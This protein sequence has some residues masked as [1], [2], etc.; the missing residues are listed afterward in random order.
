[1]DFCRP[2][3]PGSG[4]CLRGPLPF[5]LAA[6]AFAAALLAPARVSAQTPSPEAAASEEEDEELRTAKAL[7]RAPD[8][9][10]GHLFI[11]AKAGL[12][13]PVGSFGRGTTSGNFA[14][15]GGNFGG[16][17]GLGLGRHVVVEATG[18]YSLLS[19]PTTLTGPNQCVGCNGRSLDLGLGFSYHLAQG[20]AVD[21]WGSFGLGFRT[22][23]FTTATDPNTGKPVQD[24]QGTDIS[25]AKTQSFRGLDFARIGLGADFYPAPAFGLGLYFQANV[26]VRTG[27]SLGEKGFNPSLPAE[28]L[29]GPPVYAFLQIGLRIAL[30]P[31]RS[32]SP[33]PRSTEARR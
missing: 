22:A 5:A 1:V 16:V 8:T 2:L 13:G 20:V 7:P 21:P 4:R 9:R 23:S 31:F 18:G 33:R 10:A 28:T 6:L 14:G 17:I 12:E 29:V 26:G 15:L 32:A 11:T 19:G 30:D 24:A 27:G 3:S 25:A